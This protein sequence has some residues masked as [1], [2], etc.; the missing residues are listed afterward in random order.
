MTSHNHSSPIT[1]CHFSSDK[2]SFLNYSNKLPVLVSPYPVFLSDL[3]SLANIFFHFL[4]WSTISSDFSF[5]NWS[6]TLIPYMHLYLSHNTQNRQEHAGLNTTLNH[7]AS[8]GS[9][10]RRE[11]GSEWELSVSNPAL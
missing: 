5:E 2:H 6:Y 7:K 11:S 10:S 8:S 4:F 9:E 1:S 3:Y